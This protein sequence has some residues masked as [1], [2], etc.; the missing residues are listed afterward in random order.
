[1]RLDIYLFENGF[2]KS[3]QKA[4]ELIGAGVVYLNSQLCLKNSIEIMEQD[5][6]EVKLLKQWVARSA[7]KLD[8]FLQTQNIEIQ[9]KRVLDI[10]SSTGG[11]AEVLL[12][13][14]AN[15]VVCVDVGDHQLHLTLR[16]NPKIILHENQDIR[17]FFSSPFELVVCDVSFISLRLIIAKIF[18]LCSKECI[19]LFKPQFE[20]GKAVKRNKRGVLQDKQSVEV[21]LEKFLDLAEEIGFVVQDCQKSQVK[22]KNGNEEFFI[23]LLRF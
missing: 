8:L 12:E 22:G 20:V 4:Q 21:A 13:R 7:Q 16:E 2:A 14:G 3:R 18:E 23:H 15:E 11:F 6:V 10:G 17:T 1:M 9:N 5:R 19:L